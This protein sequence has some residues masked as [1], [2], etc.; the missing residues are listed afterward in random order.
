MMGNLKIL[1]RFGGIKGEIQLY[2]AEFYALTCETHLISA[3]LMIEWPEIYIIACLHIVVECYVKYYLR[4]G[5]F[6]SI[7]CAKIRLK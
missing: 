4:W 1:H 5:L 2:D 7:S 6:G 3:V